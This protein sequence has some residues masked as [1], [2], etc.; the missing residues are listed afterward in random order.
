MNLH[1]IVTVYLKELKDSLRDRRTLM[2]VIIIPTLVMPVMFFGLGKIMSVIVKKAQEE[3]PP[4]AIIGGA[5]SPGVV[6]TMKKS[7]KL[8]IVPTPAD[9]KQAI[10]D[11]KIRA[12]VEIPAG[13][14]A[15]LKAGAAPTVKISYYMGEML[16]RHGVDTVE[17]FL[18][19]LRDQT[20]ADRLA[21]HGLAKTLARPFEFKHEN[22]APPEKVGGNNLGGIVPYIIIILCFTGA[23]YPAMDLT[24]GE[25]ERGTMETLLCSPVARTDL[26]I[27][28]F[29]MV[30]T[31][32]LAAMLLSLISM[33]ISATFAGMLFARR[34]D[35]EACARKII[36][37]ILAERPPRR[38][39]IGKDAFWAGKLKALLPA[40]WW[41]GLLRRVY[42]LG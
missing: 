25:K 17:E 42:G 34:M 8:K 9:W 18:S 13:F 30:L 37:A 23:M 6:T 16:S 2:S 41:E 24:A 33:G 20:V 1:N 21:E 4:I 3:I 36:R 22:V 14:E 28:K 10:S 26:V 7:P 32:S 15:G 12:V 31:G 35:A 5:D 27:G 39:V 11:K 29:L 19:D 38:V 40:A